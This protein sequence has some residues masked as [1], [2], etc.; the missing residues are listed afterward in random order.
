MSQIGN[1]AIFIPLPSWLPA[2]F[3]VL[4]DAVVG[5]LT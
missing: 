2:C 4:Q 1:H 5:N 3:I